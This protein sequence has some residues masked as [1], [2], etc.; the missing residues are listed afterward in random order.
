MLAGMP[1]EAGCCT[2]STDPRAAAS[3]AI[4]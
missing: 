4:L 1:G 3:R 2:Y